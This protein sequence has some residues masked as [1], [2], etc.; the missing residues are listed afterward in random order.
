MNNKLKELKE[1]LHDN[2]TKGTIGI[3]NSTE[4]EYFSCFVENVLNK[5]IGNNYDTEIVMYDCMSIYLTMNEYR[6]MITLKEVFSVDAVQDC[7]Y[8][9]LDWVLD[10][11]TYYIGDGYCVVDTEKCKVVDSL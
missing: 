4:F 7:V 11:D 10:N 9:E 2:A 3:T 5:T 1:R 8:W 6:L